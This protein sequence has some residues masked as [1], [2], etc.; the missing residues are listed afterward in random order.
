MLTKKEY[1]LVVTAFRGYIR[2]LKQVAE[3]VSPDSREWAIGTV[4]KTQKDLGKIEG[5]LKP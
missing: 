3:N 2:E 5:K 1:K 4:I